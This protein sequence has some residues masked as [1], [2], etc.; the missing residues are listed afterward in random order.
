M[1]YR[2]GL[3][4]L[5]RTYRQ[6]YEIL[7]HAVILGKHHHHYHHHISTSASNGHHEGQQEQGWTEDLVDSIPLE[8]DSEVC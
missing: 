7:F 1:L 4:V 8:S 6:Y 2:L 5:R 3:C